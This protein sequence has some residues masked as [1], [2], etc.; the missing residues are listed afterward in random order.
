MGTTQ[1]APG[2]A[3]ES[4]NKRAVLER[5]I[6][7]RISSNHAEWTIAKLST[8]FGAVPVF[9]SLPVRGNNR[10]RFVFSLITVLITSAYGNTR[11]YHC[12][13]SGNP[14]TGTEKTVLPENRPAIMAMASAPPNV[15]ISELEHIMNVLERG[16]IV[17]RFYLKKRPEK[18]TLR[19]RKETRQI[20]W[21][22]TSCTNNKTFDGS[23]NYRLVPT[24]ACWP[25]LGGMHVPLVLLTRTQFDQ[26]VL[27]LLLQWT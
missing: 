25:P 15:L 23:R 14:C 5:W 19:L 16:T 11:S 24:L 27:L 20:L 4:Q 9:R 13:Q 26:T 17:T 10:Y 18:R 21:S 6:P 12:M 1:P 7:R 3:T 8:R 2:F 22:R